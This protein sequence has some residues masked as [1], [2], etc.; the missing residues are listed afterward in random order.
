MN[1]TVEIKG[2]KEIQAKLT[3]MPAQLKKEA[4]LVVQRGAQIWRDGALKDAPKDIAGGIGLAGGITFT[5]NPVTN[6]KAEVISAV[7]YSPYLEWGTIT[8][9]KVPAGEQEYAIQFKGKGIRKTG[10]IYP[11][12][13]FFKQ[14]PIAKAVVEDGLKAILNDMKL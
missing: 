5:P 7:F 3:S 11:H 10:G 12:P 6:L 13:F 1:F 9:V 4:N 8:R 14:Q 2:L